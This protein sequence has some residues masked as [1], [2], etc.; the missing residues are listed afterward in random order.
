[1]LQSFH[2]NGPRRWQL[3]PQ[4]NQT[5]TVNGYFFQVAALSIPIAV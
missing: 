3:S 2:P 1:M 5:I 4:V